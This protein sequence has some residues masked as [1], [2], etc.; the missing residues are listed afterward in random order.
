MGKEIKGINILKEIE[1]ELQP[2]ISPSLSA[3]TAEVVTSLGNVP[4]RR[5]NTSLELSQLLVF[6]FKD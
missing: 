5:M 1:G 4:S 2:G 3:I 6:V